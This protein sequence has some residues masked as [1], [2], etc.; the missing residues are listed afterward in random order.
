MGIPCIEG[1][2]N[3]GIREVIVTS[4]AVN[5][6]GENTIVKTTDYFK[7][8]PQ[9][10]ILGAYSKSIRRQGCEPQISYTSL[11]I[12]EG[13]RGEIIKQGENNPQVLFQLITPPAA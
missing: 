4:P 7:L 1:E 2:N 11:P 10:E 12:P 13:S 6:P 9:G 3:N 8:G 5:V